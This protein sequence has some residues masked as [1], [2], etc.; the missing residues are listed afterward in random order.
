MPKKISVKVEGEKNVF[1]VNATFKN[2]GSIEISGGSTDESGLEATFSFKI[3]KQIIDDLKRKWNEMIEKVRREVARQNID[4]ETDES[5][6]K[7]VDL[8]K[9]ILEEMGIKAD[10]G[11]LASDSNRKPE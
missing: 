7:I 2:D 4:L 8:I 1:D 3:P 10:L 6:K 5:V 11:W 9:K